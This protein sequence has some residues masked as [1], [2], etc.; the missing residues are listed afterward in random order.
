MLAVVSESLNYSARLTSMGFEPLAFAP[1]HDL[2]TSL[3]QDYTKLLLLLSNI[4]DY[5]VR[6]TFPR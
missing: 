4:E 2:M 3:G 6:R 5:L 1:S